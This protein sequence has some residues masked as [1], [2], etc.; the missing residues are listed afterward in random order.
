MTD[1][2][3]GFSWDENRIDS[4]HEQ[5]TWLKQA[6]LMM[7]SQLYIGVAFFQSLNAGDNDDGKN[8]LVQSSQE[9]HPGIDGLREIIAY[10][11][12]QHTVT[13]VL[14]SIQNGQLKSGKKQ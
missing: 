1:G 11:Y 9:F 3:T 8:A 6:Y 13:F 10:E 14:K 4:P 5:A 2:V 7:R 12:S